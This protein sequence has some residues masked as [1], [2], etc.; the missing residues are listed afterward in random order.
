M[1]DF[2]VVDIV[3]ID[4]FW[5]STVIS[6]DLVDG[7]G[8]G[9]SCSVDCG[10]SRAGERDRRSSFLLFCKGSEPNSCQDITD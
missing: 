7:Y 4:V 1:V 8:P 9:C 2:F 5:F 10:I 6:K 3:V